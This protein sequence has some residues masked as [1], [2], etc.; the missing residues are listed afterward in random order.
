MAGRKIIGRGSGNLSP[1]WLFLLLSV[2][3][4]KRLPLLFIIHFCKPAGKGI[5]FHFEEACQNWYIHKNVIVTI[6][7]E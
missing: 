6:T 1:I 7:L 5:V 4:R 2:L 3:E